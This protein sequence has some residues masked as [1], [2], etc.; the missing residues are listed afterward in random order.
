MNA[1]VRTMHLPKPAANDEPGSAPAARA[2]HPT[3]SSAA[4]QRVRRLV[5]QVAP[6]DTTALILGE[7]GTGKE[8][9]A[10]EL[11]ALSSRSSG[12][13]VPVNCGAI[14]AELMES[15]LFGHEKG[16]FT[17]AV[18]QRRGRF[19][20]AHG[21]TLFLDE[22]SEM[23]PLMQVKLL[24]VL[25][26]RV[27]ERVGAG[28]LREADV[29]II[30]ATNRDLEAEVAAG[31]FRG[32]LFFRLNV[33]PIQLPPLR[34]RLEDLPLLIDALSERLAL[35]GYR[36]VEFSVEAMAQLKRLRWPGNVREL[37]NLLER[38][39]ISGPEGPVARAD[40]PLRYSGGAVAEP[41]IPQVEGA[42]GEHSLS[43]P[44][45]GIALRA[46]LA[47]IEDDLIEQAMA[48]SGGVVAEAA[49][50]LGIG[51]TTLLEKLKR[52]QGP[53]SA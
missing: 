39:A 46:V 40:L 6:F 43:L 36:Q 26:E 35:R 2:S 34:E 16:A 42:G 23:S 17:G 19:E 37:E 9:V 15:E 27:Y 47:R 30:A 41:E 10:R 4:A 32:D 14:P 28:E 44:E 50:L 52:R 18:S 48:R 29:R 3:G 22:V 13:F 21:G 20:L 33:F 51:R 12:P 11:H 1:V 8:G 53:E 45:E 7:S 24:R 25:Q 49:R 5:G 38:L 31:R